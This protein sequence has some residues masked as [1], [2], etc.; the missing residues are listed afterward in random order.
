MPLALYTWLIH[1]ALFLAPDLRFGF[2]GALGDALLAVLIYW[3]ESLFVNLKGMQ[4]IVPARPRSASSCRDCSPPA[5]RRRRTPPASRSAHLALAMLAYSLF[6]IGAM[7]A[8]L[9]ALIERRLHPR[10]PVRWTAGRRKARPP[11]GAADCS[12]GPLA[13]PPPLLTLERLLFR[14]LTLGFV[15]LTLTLVTGAIYSEEVFG[16]AAA[17]TTRR[18]SR[19]SRARSSASCSPDAGATAGAGGALRLDACR[20]RDAAARLRR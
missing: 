16:R 14:I 8:L 10:S 19:S 20:V 12:Q 7:H 1:Q 3:F 4:A 13:S 17:S 11:G 5:S 9:M 6:T 2:A 18:C 15:M